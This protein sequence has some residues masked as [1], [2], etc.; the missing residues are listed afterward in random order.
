MKPSPSHPAGTG[1]RSDPPAAPVLVAYAS[2]HG[3]TRGVA[4]H[5]TAGLRR[6]GT[7]VK[8][9]AV[10]EVTEVAEYS[11]IVLGSPVYNQSWLP[12]AAEFVQRNRDALAARPVWLFSVG[13][14]GDRHPLVGRLMTREPKDIGSLREAIHPRDYRVFAGVIARDRWPLIGRLF[15]NALGGRVGDNRDWAA[16]DAWTD[17]I[18]EVLASS[19]HARADLRSFPQHV[20]GEPGMAAETR[21]RHRLNHVRDPQRTGPRPHRLRRLG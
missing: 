11:A 10:D 16:I 4:E 19:P 1:E 6:H 12:G 5:I 18:V 21:V 14:L 17:E 15:L 8:L 9:A 3:S 7:R 13:A 2:A 20:R